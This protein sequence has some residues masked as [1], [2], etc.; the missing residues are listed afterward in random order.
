[1]ERAKSDGK[2]GF[3]PVL[4]Y[5]VPYRPAALSRRRDIADSFGRPARNHSHVQAIEDTIYPIL[6][7]FGL[8]L[9]WV[10]FAE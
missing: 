2:T 6:A 3:Q 5:H 9:L 4:A 7:G 10:L 8:S 1:M